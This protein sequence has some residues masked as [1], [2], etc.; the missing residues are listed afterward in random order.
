[1]EGK[2]FSNANANAIVNPEGVKSSNRFSS[3]F[4]ALFF[5][6]PMRKTDITFTIFTAALREGSH[7]F[8]D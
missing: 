3:D 4:A 2:L 7:F 6:V 5:Y 8:A 1:M